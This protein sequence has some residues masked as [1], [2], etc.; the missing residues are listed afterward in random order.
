MTGS[1]FVIF[2]SPPPFRPCSECGASV[3][4]AAADAHV[5]EQERWLDHQLFRLRE[6]LAG[7]E[8]E[9]GAYLASPRGRFELW[10]AQHTRGPHGRQ[11]PRG[12]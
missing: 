12:T 8:S 1:P 4:V 7:L 3:A 6:D 2:G 5:C 10:C 9:V 11:G